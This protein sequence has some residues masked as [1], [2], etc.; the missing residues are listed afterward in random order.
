MRFSAPVANHAFLDRDENIP[1]K[2]FQ[3][4]GRG[5]DA[6]AA[7]LGKA[8]EARIDFGPLPAPREVR[9]ALSGVDAADAIATLDAAAK[10]AGGASLEAVR[11]RTEADRSGSCRER[12]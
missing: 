2:G 1:Y 10:A 4:P 6:L 8:L 7:K 12:G 3:A 9:A 11:T 5:S